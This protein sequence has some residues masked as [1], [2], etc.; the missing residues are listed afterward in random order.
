MKKFIKTLMTCALSL[1]MFAFLISAARSP[2]TYASTAEDVISL[3]SIYKGYSFLFVTDKYQAATD[4]TLVQKY[5]PIFNPPIP[6]IRYQARLFNSTGKLQL[7]STPIAG[8]MGKC[9]R[10]TTGYWEGDGAF[11]RGWTW[12]KDLEDN[13]KQRPLPATRTIYMGRSSSEGDCILASLETT[14]DGNNQYP[15]NQLGESYGLAI[16]ADIV[17]EEP[18]LI[19]AVGIDGNEG[20]VRAEELSADYDVQPDEVVL[21]PLYDVNGVEVGSFALNCMKEG[22]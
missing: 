6:Y 13:E 7:A 18:D 21:I 10:A 22:N 12:V 1:T 8:V 16:L 4:I 3:G 17:G 9:P 14:L 15:I 20:Y 11:S 5:E 19:A 2:D